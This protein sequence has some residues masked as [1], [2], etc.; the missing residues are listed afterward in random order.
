MQWFHK[1]V[2]KT[3][4]RIIWEHGNILKPALALYALL[5]QS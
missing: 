2:V 1:L 5:V 4:F 3:D